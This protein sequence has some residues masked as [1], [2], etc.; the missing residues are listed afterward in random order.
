MERIPASERTRERLKALMEGRSEMSEERTKRRKVPRQRG[1]RPAG[2]HT[3]HPQRMIRPNSL[4]KINVEE[5]LPRSRVRAPQ[6][7]LDQ[8]HSPSESCLEQSGYA[9]FKSL[10][11]PLLAEAGWNRLSI[12]PLALFLR[13]AFRWQSP[14]ADQTDGGDRSDVASFEQGSYHSAGS[15][16]CSASLSPGCSRHD[17]QQ[18]GEHGR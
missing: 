12:L 6:F 13:S 14:K 15:S 18:P 3:D 11:G 7:S 17:P 1:K 4:L 9:F 5:K 16:R 8:P 10:L 2:Q